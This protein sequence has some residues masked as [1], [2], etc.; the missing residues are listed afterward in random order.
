[1]LFGREEV[2][3]WE[4]GAKG[5]GNSRARVGMTGQGGVE[6]EEARRKLGAVGAGPWVGI[7]PFVRC[8]FRVRVMVYAGLEVQGQCW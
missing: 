1:M 4:A 3:C 2:N 6:A 8:D 7:I 5:S